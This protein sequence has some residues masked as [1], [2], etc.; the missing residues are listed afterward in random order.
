MKLYVFRLFYLQVVH[1][2]SHLLITS[3]RCNIYYWFFPI[4][5]WI[6]CYCTTKWTDLE[7]ISVIKSVC[8]HY[9]GY[10][11]LGWCN[12]FNCYKINIYYLLHIVFFLHDRKHKLTISW[13]NK[14]AFNWRD[15]LKMNAW[16]SKPV[17]NKWKIWV[18]WKIYL[19]LIEISTQDGTNQSIQLRVF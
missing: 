4:S 7:I 5:C 9:F 11:V 18:Y 12:V 19:N 1:L 15:V 2:L 17:N 14:C 13:F 16:R 8:M 3:L 6:L 10:Q